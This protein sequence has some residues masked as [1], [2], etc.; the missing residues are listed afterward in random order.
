MIQFIIPYCAI[1][2]KETFSV[3]SERDQDTEIESPSNEVQ[4]EK[5]Q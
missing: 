5:K 4:E 2:E 1:S 3:C